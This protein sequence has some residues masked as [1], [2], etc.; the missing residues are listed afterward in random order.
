MMKDGRMGILMRTLQI[1]RL[2]KRKRQK[3]KLNAN[4]LKKA[5]CLIPAD[6]L[7]ATAQIAVIALAAMV[8]IE[9]TVLHLQAVREGDDDEAHH[10]PGM[11]G[12]VV[13]PTQAVDLGLGLV[14]PR[15]V[16]VDDGGHAH[17][18]LL[19]VVADHLR[20]GPVEGWATLRHRT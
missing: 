9:D 6:I 16:A 19:A 15:Q 12:N 1:C 18:H 20:R 10:D 3:C 17:A 7:G 14:Q 4:G 13:D 2:V 5:A 8:V 11:V